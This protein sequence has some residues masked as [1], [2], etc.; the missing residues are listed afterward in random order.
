VPDWEPVI[1][2]PEDGSNNTYR[3]EIGMPAVFMA[4]IPP[5]IAGR[6]SEMLDTTGDSAAAALARS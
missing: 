4:N 1:W 2:R 3:T 5:G 6:S